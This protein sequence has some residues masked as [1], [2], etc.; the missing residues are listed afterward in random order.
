[1]TWFDDFT[2]KANLLPLI[3]SVPVRTS[4]GFMIF[5]GFFDGYS[6]VTWQFMGNAHGPFLLGHSP[7]IIQYAIKVMAA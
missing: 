1:L 4:F 3:F 7:A 6:T 5:K 2:A